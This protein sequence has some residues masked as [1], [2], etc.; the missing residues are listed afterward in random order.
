MKRLLVVV[1]LMVA[2]AAAVA[3]FGRTTREQQY[4]RLLEEGETAL[5]AGRAYPAI[6]AFS[7][8]LALNPRSVAALYRRGEAYS[9]QG[10]FD[11][12]ARDLR[13]A[14]SIAP[15][16][17]QPLEGLGRLHDRQ[18]EYAEAARWYSQ[19]T[20]TLRD[21]DPALLYTLALARYRA[22]DA[23]G[24]RDPLRLALSIDD[25]M[26][27][28]HFL[29]GVV[30]RDAQEPE[31][32][33]A[34]LEHTIRLAPGFLP[35]R[36]ELADLY[37]S[38]GRFE[39]ER[40]QLMA[41]AITDPRVSRSLALAL[42]AIRAGDLSTARQMLLGLSASAPTDSR[43][44]LALGRLHLANAEGGG[45]PRAAPLALAALER[46][47]AGTARRSEGLALYGRALHLSGDAA[48][49]E[50]LLLEAAA[51]TPVDRDAFAFLADV[52]EDLHHPT[53]ARDALLNLDALEGDTVSP[54]VRTARMRRL[55]VL[56]L[57]AGDAATAVRLLT[58]VTRA[59]VSDAKTLAL[60]AR[61]EWLAGDRDR[62]RQTLVDARAVFPDNP[63]LQ[64]LTRRFR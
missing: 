1:V 34:A 5:A 4:R 29:L 12:A 6:E 7:G 63:T 40:A 59:G 17:R 39:Q 64:A 19:A 18:G 33:I 37:R 51:T 3:L 27:R 15:D 22:G 30:Q 21:A 8:A 41:L 55:G 42:A 50:R 32:A 49:A 36:E 11:S 56:A 54:G 28:A 23:A 14:R 53:I 60:K 26:V 2:V 38:L 44:A 58:A 24:A 52:A 43:I 57:D 46:A 35:A 62:A 31:A 25:S 16:A 45:D 13:A 20:E 47:L 48:G 10:Q 9:Q 61:A